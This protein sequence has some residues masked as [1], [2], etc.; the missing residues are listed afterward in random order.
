MR[1]SAY[2]DRAL[3]IGCGQTCSQPWVLAAILEALDLAPGARVLDVGAGSGY[4]AAL[5]RAAGAARVDALEVSPQLACRARRNLN[6]AGVTGVVVWLRDGRR[7]LAERAPFD[8]IVVSAAASA[9]PPALTEQLAVGGRLV[10]PLTEPGEERLWCL[11][12]RSEDWQR[13]DLGPC[14]FVPLV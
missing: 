2:E 9:V 12:R 11:E 8:A 7:G 3:P 10:C 5:L 4:L 6:R 14:R 13:R 1:R